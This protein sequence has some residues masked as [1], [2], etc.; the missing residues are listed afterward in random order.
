VCD[1]RCKQSTST[2]QGKPSLTNMRPA[3]VLCSTP[4]LTINA[5][6]NVSQTAVHQRRTART[7]ERFLYISIS[8]TSDR[9]EPNQP[10]RLKTTAKKS[11]PGSHPRKL[12]FFGEGF[13]LSMRTW[14]EPRC[15]ILFVFCAKG[16]GKDDS[17]SPHA[18]SYRSST[19]MG[20]WSE[21][22]SCARGPL[23]ISHDSSRAAAA[24]DNRKWSI[25]MPR[26]CSNALRK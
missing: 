12:F 22:L 10:H 6:Q 9:P 16:E 7:V 19:T 11:L 13:P 8:R 4:A 17:T 23:S 2:T 1:S 18:F 3:P 21:G 15:P 5:Q 25:R 26:L 20:V 14:S 24:E